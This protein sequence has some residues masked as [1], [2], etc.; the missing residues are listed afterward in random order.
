MF[1]RNEKIEEA[2]GPFWPETKT[3]SEIMQLFEDVLCFAV[4][5]T[6]FFFRDAPIEIRMA[7]LREM[8]SKMNATMLAAQNQLLTHDMS[9]DTGAEQ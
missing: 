3:G 9:E 1:R 4:P 8:E 6:T 2:L 5:A 7:A